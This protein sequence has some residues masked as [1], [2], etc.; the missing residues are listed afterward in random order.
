MKKVLV[1]GVGGIGS[2]FMYEI[3]KL[4]EAGQIPNDYI[5]TMVDDDIVDKKVILY[6]N[7]T[8]E[9]IG[10]HKA[11]ALKTRWSKYL[12]V[13]KAEVKRV[14]N[15]QD[16]LDAGYDFIICCVDGSSFRRSMFE[17]WD[18]AKFKFI[19]MRAEGTAVA[20]F[21]SH[22]NNTTESLVNTVKTDKEDMSCQMQYE[23]EQGIIQ[24]GNKIIATIGSQVF[25]QMIREDPYFS[26]FIYNFR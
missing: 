10:K 15:L 17:L 18:T 22:E 6:Q 8:V 25:L 24:Q 7:F 21:T 3:V 23:L 9:D 14:E 11:Q 2:R 13:Y 26:K 5:F 16:Y 1:V 4:I 19:D 20:L 12:Q